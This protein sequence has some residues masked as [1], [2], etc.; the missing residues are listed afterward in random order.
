MDVDV[1]AHAP[2]V[3]AAR[4]PDP[5]G[6]RVWSPVDAMR[7]RL[8]RFHGPAHGT[9]EHSGNVFGDVQEVARKEAAV[10]GEFAADVEAVH[11]KLSKHGR[12]AVLLPTPKPRPLNKSVLIVLPNGQAT[13]SPSS[14]LLG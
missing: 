9:K 7:L 3:D 5:P 6:L 13:T 2:A 8:R 14:V 4:P 10:Q 12:V 1:A 11:Q